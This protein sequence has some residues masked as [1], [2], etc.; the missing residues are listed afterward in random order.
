MESLSSIM[1]LVAVVSLNISRKTAKVGE[2]IKPLV[3]KAQS[4]MKGMDN[5]RTQ[6]PVTIY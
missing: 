6:K 5:G 3:A 4:V 2:E 1:F